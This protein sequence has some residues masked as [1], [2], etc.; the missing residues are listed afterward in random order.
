MHQHNTEIFKNGLFTDS[1]GISPLFSVIYHKLFGDFGNK[2]TTG[3]QR[4]TVCFHKKFKYPTTRVPSKNIIE[5][6]ALLL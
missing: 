2:S 3:V 4:T 6:A 5:N 1:F